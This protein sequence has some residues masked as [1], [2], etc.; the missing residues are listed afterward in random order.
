MNLLAIPYKDFDNSGSLRA[1]N[2]GGDAYVDLFWHSLWWC[3]VLR[4]G[5]CVCLLLLILCWSQGGMGNVF[6]LRVNMPCL[7]CM[8]NPCLSPY[9]CCGRSWIMHEWPCMLPVRICYLCALPHMARKAALSI[10]AFKYSAWHRTPD[11][12]TCSTYTEKRVQACWLLGASWTTWLD[13]GVDMFEYKVNRWHRR[14]QLL[15]LEILF[16]HKIIAKT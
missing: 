15:W 11:W 1:K 8:N 4:I 16:E 2:R 10:A 3:R 14:G 6:F 9:S 7:A 5:W 12:L 13:A